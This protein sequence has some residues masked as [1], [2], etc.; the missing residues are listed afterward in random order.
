MKEF[1]EFKKYFKADPIL[2]TLFTVGILLYGISIVLSLI[3]MI[4]ELTK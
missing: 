3:E 2:G 1:K 4:I